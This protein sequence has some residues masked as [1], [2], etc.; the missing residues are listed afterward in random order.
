MRPRAA[1]RK[2]LRCLDQR[3]RMVVPRLYARRWSSR[4][5]STTPCV[6]ID[7]RVRSN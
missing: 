4:S 7:T 2:D 6:A 1:R 3:S 5:R